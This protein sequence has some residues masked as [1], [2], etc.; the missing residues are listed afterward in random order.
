MD[1][2]L[3]NGEHARATTPRQQGQGRACKKAWIDPTSEVV[4]I[5]GP[6][7]G[8]KPGPEQASGFSTFQSFLL[9][10]EPHILRG[11]FKYFDSNL[12]GMVDKS[13]F[14]NG[15]ENLE[16]NGKSM[17][18]WAELDKTDTG[19]LTLRDLDP[20]ANMLWFKFRRWCASQFDSA[21]DM[22]LKILGVTAENK[23]ANEPRKSV[24]M[25]FGKLAVSRKSTVGPRGT[26]T[27]KR[28]SEAK[29]ML[30]SLAQ[31]GDGLESLGWEEG[32][33]EV[34]FSALD[35]GD[36]GRI[37]LTHLFWFDAEKRRYKMKL[38]SQEKKTHRDRMRSSNRLK[39][40]KALADFKSF[41]RKGFGSYY[42]AWRK[43]IDLD[44]SMT[45]QRPELF[46]ACRS[47][48]WKGDV[49][50][51]W[52]ALDS[53]GCGYATLEELDLRC[54]R[55]LA[56]L[57]YWAEDTFGHRPVQSMW[58]QIDRK[59][60]VRLPYDMFC[61][62]CM[63]LGFSLKESSTRMKDMARWLDWEGKKCVSIDDL[64]FLDTWR[65]PAHLVAQPDDDAAVELKKKLKEKYGHSLRA[66]RTV[67][68]KDNSN[69]C[70]WSEFTAALKQMR[71]QG[72]VAG[73]WLSLDSDFSGGIS[74]GEIDPEANEILVTFRRWAAEEFGS[75][76]AAYKVLDKDKS[77]ELDMREFRQQIQNFGYQGPAVT[78][79]KCLDSMGQGKLHLHDVSFLDDWELEIEE[80]EK[81]ES[82]EVEK[83]DS[84]NTADS[85]MKGSSEQASNMSST[86]G[87][88]TEG[89]GPGAYDVTS[90]FGSKAKTNPMMK[91]GPK[92]TFTKRPDPSW[93][94]KL[95][96][97]G[98]NCT[99][100]T[101]N[102]PKHRK[103]A[104]TFGSSRPEARR[105]QMPG[106][107]QY[108]PAEA[109]KDGRSFSIGLRRGGW[110]HPALNVADGSHSGRLSP[111][112]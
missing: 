4:S 30:I 87:Y 65:A 19:V 69:S 109:P 1:V 110:L 45:V 34:L 107:G 84:A 33:E 50:L 75:V 11:W 89:P 28:E 48:G 103:P 47:L 41:L 38:E 15:I 49:R 81:E 91:R 8:T 53:D 98:P 104:W 100:F 64:L 26:V 72:N 17:D 77:G 95:K 66:W 82:S 106:P 31:W 63:S 7:P 37:S 80:V 35:H 51:L 97:V 42:H 83:E 27:A 14:I 112:G 73:A 18:L 59:H 23:K 24:V 32:Q 68:D 56:Q 76:R 22:L 2:P 43:A 44:G 12:N 62:Q 71:F 99:D 57:K 108:E 10:K 78:L 105:P 58:R 79:F 92:W 55:V 67:L 101:P 52:L 21:Q 6:P 85:K 40:E 102:R 74:L 86:Y 5:S 20:D 29:P 90:T 60:R 61:K 16:F 94:G 54:A 46:K 88:K 70:N 13:E 36:E 93:C 39:M 111:I 25:I 9:T 96:P 3:D